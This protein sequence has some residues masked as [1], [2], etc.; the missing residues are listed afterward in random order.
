MACDVSKQ[1]R[2]D[3]FDELSFVFWVL[4]AC[5]SE[6]VVRFPIGGLS[7]RCLVSERRAGPTVEPW[8]GTVRLDLRYGLLQT[9]VAWPS[10]TPQRGPSSVTI[11]V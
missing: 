3:S 1:G 5:Y 2:V 9:P 11:A 6:S 8:R 7:K 4:A 10:G